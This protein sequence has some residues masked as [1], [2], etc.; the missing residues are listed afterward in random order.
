MET[1]LREQAGDCAWVIGTALRHAGSPVPYQLSF[2]SPIAGATAG[3]EEGPYEDDPEYI[4][5]MRRLRRRRRCRSLKAADVEQVA[6]PG[7][8]LLRRPN[9]EFIAPLYTR[10]LVFDSSGDVVSQSEASAPADPDTIIASAEAL[11]SHRLRHGVKI[12]RDP[13]LLLR[14]LRM[15]LVS[16]PMPVF[17]V[18]FLDCKQRLIRFAELMHGTGDRVKVYPKEVIRDALA[19]GAEQIVCVRSDPRGDHQP[20]THDVEDARRLNRALALIDVPLV[21][22]LVVGESVT[23]LVQRRVI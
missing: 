14:F 19:C 12:L 10:S 4:H 6:V 21:D 3:I 11:L 18:F 13:Y 7:R 22:Y 17:A 16:Q 20:T 9:G 15:R 2:L 5:C 8:A 1:E 23:S